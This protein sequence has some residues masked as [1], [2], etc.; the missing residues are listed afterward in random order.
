MVFIEED[1]E[2]MRLVDL[3]DEHLLEEEVGQT[4][5]LHGFGAAQMQGGEFTVSYPLLRCLY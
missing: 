5:Y 2:L 4:H 1:E 3:I